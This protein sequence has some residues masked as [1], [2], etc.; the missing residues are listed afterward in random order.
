MFLFLSD[1][2]MDEPLPFASNTDGSGSA[3]VISSNPNPTPAA[4][5]G[6]QQEVLEDASE[7]IFP[8]EFKDAQV[9]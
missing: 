5:P 2:E 3:N 4:P 8:D 7:L 6:G 1:F 9:K